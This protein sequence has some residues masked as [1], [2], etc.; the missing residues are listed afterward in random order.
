MTSPSQ[1]LRPRRGRRIVMTIR[2]MMKRAFL[3]TT[4][5]TASRWK[6]DICRHVWLSSYGIHTAS[7]LWCVLVPFLW[8]WSTSS[9]LWQFPASTFVVF[10]VTNT[11]FVGAWSLFAWVAS[12]ITKPG[13][14]AVVVACG[15]CAARFAALLIAY[16]GHLRVVT[17]DCERNFAKM[18][19]RWLALTAETTEELLSML[20]TTETWDQPR[21][22]SLVTIRNEY[23]SC[24]TNIMTI[25][26]RSLELV[27]EDET[28]TADGHLVLSRVRAFLHYA[29][30]LEPSMLQVISRIGTAPSFQSPPH[31]TLLTEFKT[32]VHDL[33]SAIEYMGEP[34]T[35]PPRTGLLRLISELW[36]SRHPLQIVANLSLMRAD[37]AARFNGRQVWVV[38]PD[39]H[40]ID[41]MFLPGHGMSNESTN[42]GRTVVLC[43]PNCGLYEFHHFQSDWIPFYTSRGINVCVFNYRGYG[44][45]RGYPSPHVNNM[46]G[47]AMVHHLRVVRGIAR[48]AVHGESIGGL[49]ATYV[50]KNAPGIELLVAD[51]T[52]ANLPAVAQRLVASWAGT[53]LSCVTRWQTDN[54]AN[55]LDAPCHK[56]ICCDPCDEI[57]AD[58][59]SLKAGIALRLELGDANVDSIPHR[60]TLPLWMQLPCSSMHRASTVEASAV[61]PSGTTLSESTVEAFALALE[62]IAQRAR[63]VMTAGDS[64]IITKDEKRIVDVWSAIAS[65][66]G[67]CGQCLFYASGGG[68][69]TIRAWMASL[70]VWGPS[71]SQC[72]IAHPETKTERRRDDFV[73]PIS[74]EQAHSIL[75]RIL[76]ETPFLQQDADVT[77]VLST[78]QF[79]EESMAARVLQ[80][81][82]DIGLLVP[83]NC[84]HNA[85]FSDREKE[86][87][88]THL[89]NV[90]W[91]DPDAYAQIH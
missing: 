14:F 61:V 4:G 17:R 86:A 78:V 48:L 39:G 26:G 25:L 11:T 71:R 28:L 63:L 27:D 74:L 52:F 18:C 81:S 65:V 2:M 53:A 37:L 45:C 69:E 67:H 64:A 56:V 36:Q 85:N 13:L 91:L 68:L 23:R 1:K 62:R 3:T 16:P 51:R 87:F 20:E 60:R 24:V 76:G 38:A 47:M 82:H 34:S 73:T 84:G 30:D 8:R 80:T 40:R 55:Y 5:Q 32:C 33:R 49:V 66:D 54:V 7:L 19:K 41:A 88:I 12:L 83:L 75:L 35:T 72:Q 43:N 15:V 42:T 90:G 22:E 50:A 21:I 9:C 59:S 57:I 89:I 58:S 77:T 79:L 46:D 6:S 31:A 10:A 44:R 70:L 29:E